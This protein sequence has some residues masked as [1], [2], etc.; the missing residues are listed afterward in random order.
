MTTNPVSLWSSRT[1][2]KGDLGIWVAC[3][4]GGKHRNRGG[5]QEKDKGHG[6]ERKGLQRAVVEGGK[7]GATE[8]KSQGSRA[9]NPFIQLPC[10]PDTIP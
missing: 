10:P 6:Q 1:D 8:S 5:G 9:R 4:P 7:P 3:E 2:P